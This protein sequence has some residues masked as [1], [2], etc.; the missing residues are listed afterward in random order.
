MAVCGVRLGLWGK[1]P[2]LAVSFVAARR[3]QRS[4]RL[5]LDAPCWCHVSDGRIRVLAL[6]DT[7]VPHS[8]ATSHSAIRGPG[9]DRNLYGGL[10]A[11]A[12]SD[13]KRLLSYASISHAGFMVLGLFALNRY[14]VDGTVYQLITH[15]FATSALFALT[16][17]IRLK[18]GTQNLLELGGLW[19]LAPLM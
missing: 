5:R 14:G 17:L 10:L 4:S 8:G 9:G 19:R 7:S 3:I 12:Q 15:G 16:G 6:R 2:Y 18:Y 1:D 11:L 13:L